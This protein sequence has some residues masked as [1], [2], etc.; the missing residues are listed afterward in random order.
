MESWLKAALDY[1]PRYLEFQLRHTEQP[2]C[3]IAVTHRGRLVL[4]QAFGHADLARRV[5]LTPRHRFRVASH[6]K[7][8]TAAAVMRLREQRKL[9]LD[10]LAGQYVKGLHPQIAGV[11]IAQLLSHSSGIIRDGSDAGQ[12][13]DRRPFL[14]AEEL[15]AALGTAP[16]IESNSRFKYSNH[17]FG[18]AGLVIEAVTGESYGDWI[19]REI[20]A[21]ANLEET[22]PDMPLAS[23]ALMA[24]GHSGR[25]PIGRRVTIPGDQSTRA[26]AAA[27]GFVST[28]ADLAR[29]FAQLDPAAGRS[30]LSAASRREMIRRQWRDPHGSF[31][32]HYGLGI[33]SGQVGD[34]D[35]YGHGGAFQGFISRTVM[36][37]GRAI[38]VSIVT[39][40]I[41][42]MANQWSDG[43]L[44]MLQAFERHGAPRAR[45][46]SWNGRWWSLWGVVDL[47]PMAER[48]LVATPALLA[49]F[50]DASEIEISGKTRGRIALANGFANHGEAVRRTLGRGGKASELWLGGT[51]Y[52]PEAKIADEMAQ[53]YGGAK[54][55]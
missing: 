52:L 10:D 13:Q 31:G 23:G 36:L 21:R 9:R 48:I 7:S 34:W 47:V 3:V 51:R 16:V 32:R 2:G 27:T 46:R 19:R 39:N 40:S 54:R 50:T 6:S 1:V 14:D 15:R 33:T 41:D 25:L 26:L 53:R 42:G 28:A 49:P 30:V 35:W 8:F 18:L 29:F 5:P 11:T 38:T 44:H 17:G 4:E 12:W 22:A 55:R 20:I 43:V 45:T 24:R 37:P